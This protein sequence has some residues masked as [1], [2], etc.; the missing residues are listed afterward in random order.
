MIDGHNINVKRDHCTAPLGR[1]AP[2]HDSNQFLAKTGG[3]LPHLQFLF[4][5]L[6]LVGWV[7]YW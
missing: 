5:C 4:V 7:E 6:F 3:R 1:A 2:K